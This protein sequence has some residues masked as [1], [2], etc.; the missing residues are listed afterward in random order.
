MLDMWPND[1]ADDPAVD[2]LTARAR[3][4]DAAL[5]HFADQGIKGATIR[6][7]AQAA[8]VSPGLVQHHFGSKQALREVCDAYALEMLLRHKER[9][10]TEGQ[11][12]NPGFL[13]ATHQSLL[14]VLRY[15]ARAMVEGSSAA[16]SMFD[17]TVELTEQWLAAGKLGVPAPQTEDPHAYAAVLT[18]MQ[19]G[20]LVLHEHLSRVL[21][22]DVLRPE[23]HLRMA[24]AMVDIHAQRLLSPE[25]AALARAGLDRYQATLPPRGPSPHSQEHR[26]D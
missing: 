2:D 19:F 25:L 7:I 17:D 12:A 9:A 5:Q 14:M 13:P 21:D 20:L 26:D 11:I 10:L 23:G 6:D 15:L 8:G 24:K 3:I 16:A 1:R 4:R 18:A 22:A